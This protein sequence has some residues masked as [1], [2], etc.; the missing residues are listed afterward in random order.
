MPLDQ[1]RKRTR[2]RAWLAAHPERTAIYRERR[3]A[4]YKE[5]RQVVFEGLG[6][7][8]AC[9]GEGDDR[10]LS[11]DHVRN[12]GKLERLL[13][14][15]GAYLFYLNVIRGGFDKTRYQTLCYNCNFAK[16]KNGG[17]CPHPKP[18]IAFGWCV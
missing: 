1:V 17:I 14:N 10:F 7:T 4:R 2:E 18:T 16:A 9:C 8:C 15:R 3:K 12:D 5:L 6:K 13:G 11:V